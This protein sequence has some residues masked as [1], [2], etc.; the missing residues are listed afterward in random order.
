[1][2]GSSP[3]Q[4]TGVDQH[5]AVHH[6]I[7]VHGRRPAPEELERFGQDGGPQDRSGSRFG[8]SG[9]GGV[10]LLARRGMARLIAR[11]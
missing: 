5:C 6:F 7:R 9:A 2:R 3:I 4:L 1:M 10:A 11:T 8:V